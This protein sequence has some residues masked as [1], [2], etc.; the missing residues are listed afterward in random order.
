MTH[1]EGVRQDLLHFFRRH[2]NRP[3][4][5]FLGENLPTLGTRDGGH[6]R[7]QDVQSVLNELIA[8]DII[9]RRGA[10]GGSALYWRGSNWS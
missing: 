9:G 3:G 8:G 5:S 1:L 10:G 2:L 6:H 7:P 4:S